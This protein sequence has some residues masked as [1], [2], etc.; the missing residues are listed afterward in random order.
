M[1]KAQ[2][3]ITLLIELSNKLF[4]KKII[5]TQHKLT[6][7]TKKMRGSVDKF[8]SKITELQHRF[9][10]AS[11]SIGGSINNL[12]I[13]HIQ[14]FNAMKAELPGLGRALDLLTNK[15]VLMAAGIA[16][17]GMLAYSATKK[18]ASF[19]HEFLQIT[20][21]N[22]DKPRSEME[23]YKNTIRDTAFKVG[24]DLNDTTRAFYDLQSGL[25]VF[26]ND[27][28]TIFT[29]VAK[30]SQATGADLGST[31]NSTIKSMKAFNLTAADTK[32]LLESNAKAV[33][34]GLVTFDELAKVQTIYAGSAGNIG[35]T[36]NAANKLYAAFTSL[37]E[38]ANTSATL[39][40]SF[41]E[42]L[43]RE[44]N[45]IKT[46]A[47]VD[48]FENGKMRQ[49]DDI[50]KD[51]IKNFKNLSPEQVN[52]IITKIGGSDG[53]RSILIKAKGNA[54]DLLK[55]FETYDA[56]KFNLD[57]ALKNAKGDVT[58]LANIVKNR[59]NVV[60]ATLGEYLLPIVAKGLNFF[61]KL[62]IGSV[63]IVKSAIKFYND[64]KNIINAIIITIGVATLAYNAGAIALGAYNAV[65]YAVTIATKIWTGAQWLL[66]AAMNANPIGLIV[67]AIAGLIA[68]IT[69]L[70][71]KTEGWKEQWK[72]LPKLF[73]LMW[74]GM[75]LSFNYAIETM[76]IGFHK[77]TDG[78]LKDWLKV[79]HEMGIISDKT[80][81]TR[82]T[83][84][85]LSK[86][87]RDR[88]H[89]VTAAKILTNKQESEKLWKLKWKTD[90][91]NAEKTKTEDLLAGDNPFAPANDNKTLGQTA[92]SD[93]T[94][95]TGAGAQVRNITVN[96]EAFNKGG[97]NTENT[98]L[99][100]MDAEE[101]EQWFNESMLRVVRNLELSMS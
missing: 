22:L 50:I 85:Y 47:K 53:L 59:W 28:K 86:L 31:I 75:K 94:K 78:M 81:K 51:L 13:K 42:G 91:E 40:K 80:Y 23:A 52:N 96:I 6:S 25:G 82:M 45:K 4:N 36:I 79:Q 93:I 101:I 72:A 63:K 16:G 60:M 41:F 3:K 29:E 69:Y 90:K 64:Y 65:I 35:Q 32:T 2:E 61:N 89:F 58:V 1:G 76:S 24:T 84:L 73:S 39:T 38:N 10:L 7:A 68:G 12:K 66:N 9:K 62:I 49:A 30:F 77:L 11:K 55:T 26:G 83:N 34:S 14:A 20:Q 99:N 95:V 67:A 19:N 88:E 33:Y 97:I 70:I 18:A 8:K 98:T 17:I 44:A 15:Y 100:N 37:G 48:V 54:E 92:G 87:K 43:S 71:S 57:K 5:E 56:S 27:A 21:M 74:D 46:F